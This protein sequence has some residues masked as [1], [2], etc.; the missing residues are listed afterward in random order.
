[1]VANYHL[2][3]FSIIGVRRISFFN[4]KEEVKANEEK[5]Q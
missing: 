2:P 5:F 4:K 1:M 3:F